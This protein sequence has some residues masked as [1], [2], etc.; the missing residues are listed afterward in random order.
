MK[1][2]KVLFLLV[3]FILIIQTPPL[4]KADYGVIQQKEIIVDKQVIKDFLKDNFK[5][6]LM[7]S[8]NN[9]TWYYADSLLKVSLF[10]N[11]FDNSYKVNLTLDTNDAPQSLY[12]RFDL[13]FNKTV[14]DY[15]EIDGWR[16]NINVGEYNVFFDWSDIKE[17]VNTSKVFIK[18]GIQN[19]F[20]WFRVQTVN[21]IAIDK[22]FYVD[23]NYGLVTG[24]VL[25]TYEFD[26]QESRND[27]QN[28]VCR[29][30]NT[31]YWAIAFTGDTG[32][33]NDGF[34][35]TVR[36]HNNNGTIQKSI[37][38]SYEYDTS[39]G[40]E[41][42][43]YKRAGTN[44]YVV[45]YSDYTAVKTYV[46]TFRISDVGII[47]NPYIDTKTLTTFGYYPFGMFLTDDIF[48]VSIY[49]STSED[50]FLESIRINASGTIDDTSKDTEEFDTTF[51]SKPS[52]CIVDSGTIA[53]SYTSG[54]GTGDHTLK[55]LN[56][57]SVGIISSYTD[58]WNYESDPKTGSIV[59]KVSGNI[60]SLTYLDSG[61][62]VN[63][64]TVSISNTGMITKSFIDSVEVWS[65]A[66]VAYLELFTVQDA[67]LSKNGKGILGCTF[68]GQSI[69]ETDGYMVTWNISSLGYL[70][71]AFLSVYEFETGQMYYFGHV[72]YVNKSYYAVFF[73]G[74][75]YDGFVI[76]LNIGTNWH[77]TN[78]SAVYPVNYATGICLHPSCNITTMDYNGDLLN[79]TFERLSGGVWY[80]AQV[81]NSVACNGTYRWHFAEASSGATG[82]SWRLSV[83]DGY[84][85]TSYAY[86][87]TTISTAEIN[88]GIPNPPSGSTDIPLIGSWCIQINSSNGEIFNWN[89]TLSGYGSVTGSGDSNGTKCLTFSMLS[90]G[91]NYTVWVN[92]SGRSVSNSSKYWFWTITCTYCPDQLYN[93]TNISVWW[94]VDL[95][96]DNGTFNYKIECNNS[97]NVSGTWVT[98][99][100]YWIHL[101]N[102]TSTSTYKIYVNLSTNN[103]WDNATYTL[104]FGGGVSA[105]NLFINNDRFTLGLVVGSITFLFAGMVIWRRRKKEG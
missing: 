74:A 13:A 99:G 94:Y 68:R 51:C 29:I 47:T 104:S 26:A 39:N 33:D 97:Q 4:T 96:S 28:S 34:L 57:S 41:A 27:A 58:T 64:K 43:I 60:Y 2:H 69:G 101:V 5:W 12:Y 45:L 71:S 21:K 93:H 83:S 65:G 85:N 19:S 40:Y 70:D 62:D 32:T 9:A 100:T 102:L 95:W 1:S 11:D 86:Y 10:W 80:T 38:S 42:S 30:N 14:S 49:E 67:S 31:E 63:C 20:F 25:S 81:N 84:H 87:F 37:V 73:S 3:V 59:E 7:A 18:K 6:R 52:M 89:I 46:K 75:D 35:R 36:I 8:P 79:I 76:T 92:A 56:I 91:T 61:N 17:L 82:Y 88:Y 55:T 54:S 72:E 16:W 98:N 44:I 53:L 78:V 24:S 23:P 15:V 105:S 66:E 22:V 50:G 90:C 103:C 77:I 48:L